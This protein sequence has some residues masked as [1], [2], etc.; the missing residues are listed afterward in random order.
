MSAEYWK[1]SQ[2]QLGQTHESQDQEPGW[3]DLEDSG[4]LAGTGPNPGG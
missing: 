4:C 3:K 2:S 1:L